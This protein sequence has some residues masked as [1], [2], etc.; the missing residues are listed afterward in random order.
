MTMTSG[1]VV[2]VAQTPFQLFSAILIR[3]MLGTPADLWLLDP[4][5]AR[6]QKRC[7]ELAAWHEVFYAEVNTKSPGMRSLPARVGRLFKVRSLQ[8]RVADYLR[9]TRP[10]AVVIFSD[11]HEITAAFA[12][13]GQEVAHARVIMA[14]E[15]NATSA[16]F[17]RFRANWFKRQLRR[18]LGIDNPE[19][20][21]IGWSP[22]IHA[23]LLSD[24]GSA[25]A[26]Y[27]QRR[28]VFQYPSGPYPAKAVEE[29]LNLLDL[30]LSPLEGRDIVYLGGAWDD[31][32]TI[33]EMELLQMLDRS[34]L[35]P[36]LLLKPHPFDPAGK[37]SSLKRILVTDGALNSVPAELIL[38]RIQPGVVVSLTSSALIN[39][40]QRYR[41]PGI[42]V[43]LPALPAD[44]L[45][46]LDHGLPKDEMLRVVRDPSEVVPEIERALAG[47]KP[48]P[49]GA[50]AADEWRRVIR[51]A[52]G[53]GA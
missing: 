9:R 45:H 53:A 7:R 5:L 51:C 43:A 30:D 22:H 24:P 17:R 38:G 33:P 48:A 14:E 8:S 41:R 3:Q 42:F 10:S 18:M 12:R 39:Y 46:V 47:P 25:H 40:C 35:A 26:D 28:E 50:A 32:V 29:H 21:S 13:L 52:L 15:G 49:A 16:S 4:A 20:Y 19:G 2:I 11:N 44:V 23:L 6:Y 34:A 36:R 1:G 31:S 37:Y 27:L